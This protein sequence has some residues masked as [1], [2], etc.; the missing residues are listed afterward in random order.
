MTISGPQ[1]GKPFTGLTDVVI[2]PVTGE[3]FL[4]DG[5]RRPANDRVIKFDKSG[6]YLTEWGTPGTAPDQIGIPHGLAMDKEGRIYVADRSNKAVKVFDQDGKLLHSWTQ[7]G[8]PSGVYVDK[9]DLLYVADETA[10]MPDNP[11]LSPGVRIAHVGDGKIIAN[12]PYRQGNA[13]EGV[14]VDDAGNIYGGNTN[15]PR[16]VRWLKVGPL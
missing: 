5:H 16:S 9:N 2:S 4:G 1:G 6:K 11:K 8:A 7:F 10:N 13:L 3:I 12:V 15:H 14:A